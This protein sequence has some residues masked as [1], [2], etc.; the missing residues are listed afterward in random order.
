MELDELEGQYVEDLME[1]LAYQ[2][3]EELLILIVSQEH[4]GMIYEENGPIV[5]MVA[6]AIFLKYYL[7]FKLADRFLEF[8]NNKLKLWI[9]FEMFSGW[10]SC[11]R[12]KWFMYT[13]IGYVFFALML[14]WMLIWCTSSPKTILT[15][16]IVITSLTFIS[17]AIK[18][19]NS[20]G[21]TR[22]WMKNIFHSCHFINKWKPQ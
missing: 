15:Q 17:K 16:M 14:Q 22:D 18:L 2:Q 10:I 9:N 13:Y 5:S 6:S 7:L 20:T 4:N 8:L 21:I 11:E 3:L 1:S 19:R 12:I